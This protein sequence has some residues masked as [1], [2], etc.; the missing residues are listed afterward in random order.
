[1]RKAHDG[2]G[3]KARGCRL[4]S[5]KQHNCQQNDAVYP[6]CDKQSMSHIGFL[7]IRTVHEEF[8]THVRIKDFKI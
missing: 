1:M 4:G 3:I 8:L 2:Q 5:Q 7:K 6:Q